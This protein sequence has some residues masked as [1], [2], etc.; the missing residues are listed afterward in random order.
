[1]ENEAMTMPRWTTIIII[2]FVGYLIG[3]KF[4]STG[5]SLLAKIGA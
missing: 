1:M 5:T 3:A 2:L 4:P